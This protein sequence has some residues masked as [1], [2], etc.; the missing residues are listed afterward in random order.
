V[1]QG[2]NKKGGLGAD[3]GRGDWRKNVLRDG[4]HRSERG[5]LRA[6]PV[7]GN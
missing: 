6:L 4:Y 5:V 1:S 7:V 3:A 2:E